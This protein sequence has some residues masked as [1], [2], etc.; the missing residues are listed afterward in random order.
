MPFTAKRHFGLL[1]PILSRERLLCGD[2]PHAR[3]SVLKCQRL[4][5]VRGIRV[6]F[7]HFFSLY[8][9]RRLSVG[10]CGVTDLERRQTSD[11]RMRH[12]RGHRRPAHHGVRFSGFNAET[13]MMFTPHD[14]Q[15]AW[16]IMRDRGPGRW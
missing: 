8:F 14:I 13:E 9:S 15:S 6:S 4:L 12:T 1:Q 16:T 11:E 7:G 5:A 3:I 10:H 2:G